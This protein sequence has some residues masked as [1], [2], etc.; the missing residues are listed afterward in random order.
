MRTG[1]GMRGRNGRERRDRLGGGKEEWI[2][3]EKR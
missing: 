1:K 3:K 2:G